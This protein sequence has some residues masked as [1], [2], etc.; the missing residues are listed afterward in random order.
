M[1]EVCDCTVT[2]LGL[3]MP[4][5]FLHIHY[6]HIRKNLNIDEEM[7]CHKC[8]GFFIH[9]D[10]DVILSGL[11]KFAS[12]RAFEKNSHLRDAKWV[13]E[14]ATSMISIIYDQAKKE[15]NTFNHEDDYTTRFGYSTNQLGPMGSS[16]E[17]LIRSVARGG[18]AQQ[19]FRKKNTN[20]CRKKETECYN[21]ISSRVDMRMS[22]V[23]PGEEVSPEYSKWTSG[24]RPR[25]TDNYQ[26]DNTFVQ[27][28]FTLNNSLPRAS[29]RDLVR[30]VS[31]QSKNI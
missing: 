7:D 5:R 22:M 4:Q 18:P 8:I 1:E 13:V 31:G 20:I 27:C 10:V 14:D 26:K 19:A 12:R 17:F 2:L 28:P 23:K 15:K 29:E 24:N 6:K 9:S 3:K 25:V 21:I 30:L 16:E 11:D